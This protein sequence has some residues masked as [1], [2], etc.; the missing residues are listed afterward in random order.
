MKIS[1]TVIAF[2]LTLQYNL[3][4]QNKIAYKIFNAKGKSVS[5]KKLV[6][7]LST[8]DIVLFGEY[9]DNP[10]VHWLQFEVTKDLD[11]NSKL[12]LGAEMLERD[13]QIYLDKYL[14]SGVF[15][16]GKCSSILWK[17]LA[18]DT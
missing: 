11:E 1:L 3:Y 7:S 8:A 5:Y 16:V 17:N 12:I 18:R 9:H 14:N 6:K 13:N 10:I 2:L 4:S 15:L